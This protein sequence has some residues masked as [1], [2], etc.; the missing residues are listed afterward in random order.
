[1]A[2]G[3][4]VHSRGF[5]RT[6]DVVVIG[7]GIIGASVAYQ[8][9]R[10][11]NLKVILVDKAD[12]PAMGSTGASVAI[13]RCRY[14]VPEVVRLAQSSQLAYRSWQDF[15]QLGV[16]NSDYL[17]LG[18]LWVFDKT[19][20]EL[21]EDLD[22]LTEN[23]VAAEILY[24]ADVAEHWPELNKC[25]QP[26]D[27][28]R[29]HD[30]ECR[31]GE[32]F[33]YENT[34][35][36]A[37]PAGANSDLIDSCRRHG[38]QVTFG[39]GVSELVM[40][41][42]RV[43]GVLLE[44][45]DRIHSDIVIN[46]AGPWCNWINDF[47]GAQQKWTLTP[48]RIQL[49]LREWSESDPQLPITFDGSTDSCYR[50]ERSGQQILLVS[51]EISQFMETIDNPDDFRGTPDQQCVETTLAAFMHRVPGVK[52]SGRTTGVCGLYT[53]N[54]EDNHPVVGPSEVEGL[55]L[56]NGFSGHGFK[57]APGI[58]AIIARLLTG[59][60][61]SFDPDVDENLFAID[62]APLATTGGVL[63]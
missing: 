32:S 35:G 25:V 19:S 11:S 46:A 37:D 47:A 7:A 42:E 16:T 30:H 57:L 45:G 2:K 63:A 34:A 8:I 56:A 49:I 44:G 3:T 27:F 62:R 59:E 38:V 20:K 39:Q 29:P 50:L 10:R 54:E 14:T 41:G 18:A 60:S 12:G 24:A 53:V 1:M 52:H 33:L 36:I 22:R 13:S 43:S 58:G 26:I 6:A 15:T 17:E 61:A 23:G 51:P 4:S 5:K 40:D 31:S 48:T 21:A 9:A 55:W 28:V